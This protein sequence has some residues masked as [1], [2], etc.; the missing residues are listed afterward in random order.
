LRST[1]QPLKHVA[2]VSVS[3]VDKKSKDDEI[4]VRLVNYTDVYYGDR[5][6]PNLELMR[7][8]ATPAQVDSFS[9]ENGDVIITKD[10]ET[11]NDIGV[12]AFVER[13]EP[14]MVCG[15]HL[16]ILRPRPD[17]IHGRYLYWAVKGDDALGQLATSATGV[18]R[19][20]L[21]LDAISN[22]T[23]WTPALEQ[24]RA[25][26]DYLDTETAR[27]DA[28]ITKKRRMIELLDERFLSGV[29]A[30]VCGALTSPTTPTVDSGIEWV[31]EIPQHYGTP[32]LGAFHQT[33]LGKMLNSEAAAGPEQYPYVKNTNVQWD[34]LDLHDLPIMS[35]DASD[36]E[37][38]S[39]RAGDVLVCEG[40]EVGRA[41]V[42]KD[43][44]TNV[45]FQKALHRVRS[46]QKEPQPRYLMYCLWAAA[47][48]DC[49][50]V[51]GNQSTIVHLTG[52]KLREHRFPWPDVD[53][54]KQ[55]VGLL[56]TM[57]SRT[58][59]ATDVLTKQ[60][61]LLAERR[62][63]LITAAVTGELEIPRVAA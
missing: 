7:A 57:R 55:I 24:Q 54:Q 22:A 39:L 52:E 51:E 48:Q 43:D 40:G 62:Q 20:G 25:I 32:W 61:D 37:R 1:R 15:Y 14:A 42:W 3:N 63:A 17:Q 26:A 10:S 36:R 56:D 4:P 50:V 47:S 60:L 21:R 58:A 9:L 30:G 23:I 13:S 19:Y 44:G 49:F 28:L 27:I 11:V 31:G 33:Q 35:F 46:L 41:A 16:A 5:L 8:T 12:A 2:S 6:T 59:R 18:T 53:E 45:F 34:H 29:F 38:C